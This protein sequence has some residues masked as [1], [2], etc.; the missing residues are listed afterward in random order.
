MKRLNRRAKVF[1]VSI[2]TFLVLWIIVFSMGL[3]VL[4]GESMQPGLY[5]YVEGDLVKGD[6]VAFHLPEM[7]S[8]LALERGYMTHGF[9]HLRE[10]ITIKHVAASEGD[11]VKVDSSGVWVN[12]VLSETSKALDFDSSGREM[13]GFSLAEVTLK[14]GEFLVL[15]HNKPNGLDSRYYGI[16]RTGNM[17]SRVEPVFYF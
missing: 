4:T 14:K 16:L 5:Q 1:L 8:N 9:L 12:G 10:R 7:W 2:T 15:S 3:R 17:I 6:F 11:R 13:P